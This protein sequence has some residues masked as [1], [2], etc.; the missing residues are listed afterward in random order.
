MEH[1]RIF[2]NPKIYV[3][4]EQVSMMYKI[5]I[6]QA[7]QFLSRPD[8][9]DFMKASLAKALNDALDS[10]VYELLKKPH[11]KVPVRIDCHVE[12]PPLELVSKVG[13]IGE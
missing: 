7:D 5:P 1:A 10:S 2:F 9:Y 12:L 3:T 11:E 8:V 4:A 13:K 6:E